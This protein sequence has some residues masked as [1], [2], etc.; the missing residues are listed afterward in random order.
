MRTDAMLLKIQS[1]L[2]ADADFI[3]WCVNELG[4]APTIQI[5]FDE[6]QELDVDCYPAIVILAI[7]NSGDI[8]QLDNLFTV[9]MWSAVR[10]GDATEES[11][12]VSVNGTDVT[13]KLRTYKG[14]LQAEA[15]RE[16][17]MLSLYRAKLGKVEIDSD[18]LTKTYHPKFYSPF[19][20]TIEERI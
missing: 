1:A 11:Q 16:H 8:R 5:D 6:D 12:S 9:K 4:R 7:K 17:A 15:L 18:Y 10:K 20:V 19:T 14:R 2:A 3:G 13:V